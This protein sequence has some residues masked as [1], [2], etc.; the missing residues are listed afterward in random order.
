MLNVHKLHLAYYF[1]FN[2]FMFWCFLFCVDSIEFVLLLL[3]Q[4][5]NKGS[6]IGFTCQHG[7]DECNGNKIHSCGLQLSQ[8]QAQQ[9][10]FVTCQMSYGSDGSELVS[11]CCS[12]SLFL[13]FS[14]ERTLF[15]LM[16][17]LFVF[18]CPICAH[19]MELI[20]YHFMNKLSLNPIKRKK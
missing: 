12:F 20:Y 2:L 14:V 3:L 16:I 11:F 1:F 10:A 8:S 13:F 4:S 17:H 9:V 5:I 19:T 15:I 7:D 6:A 18:L